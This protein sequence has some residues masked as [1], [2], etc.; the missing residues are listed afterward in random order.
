MDQALRAKL[1]RITQ[2]LFGGGVTN[3]VTYIEQLSYL[4]FLKLLDER[5]G[6][7]QLQRRLMRGGEDEKKDV[8]AISAESL[9]KEFRQL[10]SRGQKAGFT[11]DAM[12]DAF[13][14]AKNK[15]IENTRNLRSLF[16]AQASRYR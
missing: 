8:P 4:I 10:I 16:P 13:N 2:A 12:K 14:K 6:E 11:R 5:E 1:D 3:P 7:I 9:R 15:A